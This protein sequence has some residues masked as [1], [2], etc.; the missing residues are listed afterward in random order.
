MLLK[1]IRILP[2]S[3]NIP[4][5]TQKTISCLSIPANPSKLPSIQQI[6]QHYPKHT[7][8][9]GE[10]T[11]ANT[12][13]YTIIIS[14]LRHDR[15]SRSPRPISATH[16]FPAKEGTARETLQKMWKLFPSRSGNKTF[17]FSALL[18]PPFLFNAHRVSYKFFFNLS[19]QAKKGEREEWKKFKINSWHSKLV[20]G[21]KQKGKKKNLK[22][23]CRFS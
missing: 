8:I 5:R 15:Q 14:S 23:I 11:S 10:C 17:F 9:Q 20:A 19:Q 4:C 2:K 6:K 3:T 7:L 22:I 16:N 18:P 21:K 13:K 12:Q 1:H